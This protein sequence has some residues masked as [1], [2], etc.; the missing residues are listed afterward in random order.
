MSVG[1]THE[2]R[3]ITQGVLDGD[4]VVYELFPLQEVTF[5]GTSGTQL[6]PFPILDTEQYRR[7]VVSVMVKDGIKNPNATLR[8]LIQNAVQTEDDPAVVFAQTQATVTITSADGNESL[9]T[10]TWA[11]VGPSGRLCFDWS[12]TSSGTV[13]T[14]LAV[15]LTLRAN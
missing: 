12:Q 13:T 1:V 15:W 10:A 3:I 6:V 14:R 5:N 4:A 7:G 8:V 2:P 11:V 9:S